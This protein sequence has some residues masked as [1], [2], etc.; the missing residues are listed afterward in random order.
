MASSIVSGNAVVFS[1]S[2]GANPVTASITWSLGSGSNLGVVLAFSTEQTTSTRNASSITVG[3]VSFTHIVNN[4]YGT[5]SSYAIAEIW[6]CNATDA[7]SIG[8]NPTISITWANSGTLQAQGVIV[9]VQDVDQTLS[10]WTNTDTDGQLATSALSG[11][12]IGFTAGSLIIGSY[13]DQTGGVS[14]NC[15]QT[16]GD[17]TT[18]FTS[19]DVNFNGANARAVQF[20]AAAADTT[21][22]IRV[23]RNTTSGSVYQSLVI[24]GIPDYVAPPAGPTITGITTLHHLGSATVTGTG[25]PTAQSGLAGM[26]IGGLSQ[27]VT[28]DTSTQ[29]TI[30]D[31]PRGILLYGVNLNSVVTDAAGNSSSAFVTQLNPR[32]GWSY[33]NLGGTLA[34]IGKRLRTSPD[35][36]GTE[37][38]EYGGYVGTGTGEVFDTAAFR[39]QAG[40][41]GFYY[42]VNDGVS[43]YAEEVLQ[44]VGGTGGGVGLRILQNAIREIIRDCYRNNTRG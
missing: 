39:M 38:V 36:D 34:T 17:V 31:I 37:Q 43:G 3:G 44:L 22:A 30:D 11:D 33:V 10:N 14:V 12:L 23:Q 9:T 8:S 40:V 24:A 4:A 5:G 26:T 32:S 15:A 13:C 7:A 42:A 41:T 16:G 6:A 29:F 1:T 21:P 28:W 18:E 27:S 35:L 20:Y 25:F 2:S 19:S